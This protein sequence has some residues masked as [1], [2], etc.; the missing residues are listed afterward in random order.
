[1]FNASL[2]VTTHRIAKQTVISMTWCRN[3]AQVL[4][5][6]RAAADTA[7]IGDGFM[8][9]IDDKKVTL[10]VDSKNADRVVK[11]LVENTNAFEFTY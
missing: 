8:T 2:K 4:K 1:M 10:T 11:H 3:K 9:L 7:I 6:F 5:A